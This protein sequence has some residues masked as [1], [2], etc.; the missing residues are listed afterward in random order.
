VAI[1]SAVDPFQFFLSG[2]VQW[3]LLGWKK[4]GKALHFRIR[5]EEGY[6]GREMC[7]FFVKNKRDEGSVTLEQY[8]D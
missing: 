1:D 5:K 7:I 4:Y 8:R 2:K 6:L 3:T